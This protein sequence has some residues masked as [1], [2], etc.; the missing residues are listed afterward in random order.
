MAR[1]LGVAGFE[2]ILAIKRILPHLTQD[3]EFVQMFINEAKLA[4][5]ITHPNIVQVY[6]FGAVDENYYMA[7]EYVMGKSLSHIL[8]RAKSMKASVPIDQA[9]QIVARIASGLDYAYKGQTVQ[10]EALQIIHR[11]I[12]PQNILVAYNGDVKLVDFGIAK[13]ASSSI[14]TQTGI[15]KGKL[16]YLSPEQAW[17]KKVDHRSDLFSLGIVLHEMLTGERLFKAENEFVT[18]ERVR[19][20]EVPP[21]STI[22]PHIPKELDPIV[23]KV[24]AKEPADRYQDGQA[25][26][27]ALEGYLHKITPPPNNRDL[28]D[29]L[30]VLFEKEIRSD[31]AGFK[32]ATTISKVPLTTPQSKDITVQ[33]NKS[34]PKGKSIMIGV[35][36]AIVVAAAFLGGGFYMQKEFGPSTPTKPAPTAIVAPKKVDTSAEVPS[37]STPRTPAKSITSSEP[38]PVSLPVPKEPSSKVTPPPTSREV[39]KVLKT[40]KKAPS[41]PKVP[42]LK[43]VKKKAPS[44]IIPKQVKPVSKSVSRRPKSIKASK[45]VEIKKPVKKITMPQ[46]E[47]SRPLRPPIP[48][49][50]VKKSPSPQPPKAVVKPPPPPP[51]PK[52]EEEEEFF[53]ILP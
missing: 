32:Q 43:K 41:L 48:P 16:S 8:S 26:Q 42:A 22:K 51:E 24:L 19:A 25:F 2:R 47:V 18:L 23:L 3:P 52:K 34:G 4:A 36:S 15:I 20:A 28:S 1:Q 21:P 50:T 10:G 46:R 29:Y 40:R 53:P 12:S 33:N 31:V 30:H 13:A 5:Q 11:D 9:V 37:A 14:H 17:G 49:V 35:G 6:D 38:I 44:P 27:E 7:M 45:P 39:R